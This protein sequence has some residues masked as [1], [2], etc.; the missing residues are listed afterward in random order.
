MGRPSM[1]FFVM[2]LSTISVA[3]SEFN[4]GYG[5]GGHWQINPQTHMFGLSLV[6]NIVLVFILILPSPN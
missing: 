1:G 5:Q 3:A 4:Q 2:L 6:E